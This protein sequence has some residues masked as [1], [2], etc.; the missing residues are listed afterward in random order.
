MR[1]HAD[2]PPT[3]RRHG[4]DT[5]WAALVGDRARPTSQRRRTRTVTAAFGRAVKTDHNV[6][7]RI[8]HIVDRDTWARARAS[9]SYVP[10]GFA[11]EGFVHCSFAHQVVATA[12]RFYRGVDG[13]VVVELDAGAVPAELRVEDTA[14]GGEGFPHVYGPIPT[15]AQVG[16]HVLT[17]GPDGGWTGLSRS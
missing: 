13:L 10:E 5:R 17:R 9:G 12:N 7:V 1:G 8:F 14:G 15:A 3:R 16:E 2:T 4:A 6:D 11:G